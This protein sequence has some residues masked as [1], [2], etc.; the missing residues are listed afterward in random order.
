MCVRVKW[1]FVFKSVADRSPNRNKFGIFQKTEKKIRFFVSDHHESTA[2]TGQSI[3]SCWVVAA[4]TA[5]LITA[6]E[7]V[8]KLRCCLLLGVVSTTRRAHLGRMC[9]P[10]VAFNSVMKFKR[11]G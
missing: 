3:E 6:S 11:M 9:H 10:V 7:N 4:A 8:S 2:R 1:E 5:T